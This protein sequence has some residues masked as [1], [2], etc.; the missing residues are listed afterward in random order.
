MD[1]WLV[2]VV[3][4]IASTFAVAWVA[5]IVALFVVRPRGMDLRAMSRVVPDTVRLL[6]ALHADRTLPPAVRRWTWFL[7]AYLAMPID[8]VPDVL[9]LVGYVDDLIVVALVLRRVAAAAGPD[10]IDA[11]WVGSDDGL[12]AVRR[13]AGVAG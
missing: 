11:H 1:T 6:R 10:A 5:F 7:L 12:V 13:L 8:L 9:P 3:I 4:G 2:A